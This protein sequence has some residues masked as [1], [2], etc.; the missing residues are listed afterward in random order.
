MSERM[1]DKQRYSVGMVQRGENVRE[2]FACNHG[3]PLTGFRIKAVL[4]DDEH[5]AGYGETA[6][7]AFEGVVSQF[8][9]VFP[10][11]MVIGTGFEEAQNRLNAEYS[12]PG[13][14]MNEL[15]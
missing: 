6:K 8:K 1:S 5:F 9:A 15:F 13:F 14:S 7:E 2:V 12:V 4:E 10:E 11:A 3:L